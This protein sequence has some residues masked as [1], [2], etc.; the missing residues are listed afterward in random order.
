M[1]ARDDVAGATAALERALALAEPEGYV[2][3]F[4]DEGPSMAALL[5]TCAKDRSAPGYARRLLDAIVDRARLHASVDQPLIEPL[6]ERELEVLRL[7]GSDLD[8]PDLAREL[9]V[10][11]NTVRT[12]TRNIYAKL[13]VSSRRA[14]VSRG[15]E[16]GLLAGAETARPTLGLARPCGGRANPVASPR[17]SPR[18]VMRAHHVRSDT[19]GSGR[20]GRYHRPEAQSATRT[21]SGMTRTTHVSR[22]SRCSRALRDPAHRPP[23]CA[24]GDLVRRPVRHPRG[25]RDH[26]HQRPGRRPGSPPRPAP[27]GP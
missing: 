14:A 16:L 20:S 18:L 11:L 12:H 6:S 26:R 3:V 25:R 22:R 24:L 1:H 10:S 27:A 23:R 13:G 4:L 5:R 17:K 8:G 19:C 21:R 2:R 15:A 9:T 7:L